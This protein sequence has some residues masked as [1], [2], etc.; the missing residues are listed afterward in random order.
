MKRCIAF[1][2]WVMCSFAPAAR[3]CMAQETQAA[4][5]RPDR[6]ED[7]IPYP[8]RVAA[9]E[10]LR[11]SAQ[12]MAFSPHVPNR[13]ERMVA[14]V[15]Y[16]HRLDGKDEE[17]NRLL[18]FVYR[19]QGQIE[20]ELAAV[21]VLRRACPEDHETAMRWLGLNLDMRDRDTEQRVSFLTEQISRDDLSD[22]LCAEA[23]SQLAYIYR[24][25][26]DLEQARQMLREALS[27]D[28]YN[29]TAIKGL[30]ELS[31][32]E[33][34]PIEGR[35]A[36]M[37]D[38]VAGR[39]NPE[40]VATAMDVALAMGDKG[41]YSGALEFF[42][43]LAGAPA[44]G[45]DQP[46]FALAYLSALLDAGQY[47]RA[48]EIFQPRIEKFEQDTDFLSLMVETYRAAG[49][50]QDARRVIDRME[51]YYKTRKSAAELKP[52]FLMELA[53]FNLHTLERPAVALGYARQAEGSVG[54]DPVLKRILGA[55]EL[56]S[57]R[58]ELVASGRQRLEK[59]LDSDVYAAAYLAE[60]YFEAGRNEDARRVILAGAE[61]TRSGPAY[62]QLS[63]VAEEHDVEMPPAPDK[64]DKI[65][66]VVRKFDRRYLRMLRAPSEF[67]SVRIGIPPRPVPVGEAVRLSVTLTNRGDIDVPLGQWGLIRPS[68]GFI[69]N[70]TDSDGEKRTFGNLPILNLPAPAR[71]AP[72]KSIS[73][74][75]RIDVGE[76]ERYLARRPLDTFTMS[77]K[78]VVDPVQQGVNIVSAAPKIDAGDVRVTRAGL[79]RWHRLQGNMSDFNPDDRGTWPDAYRRLMGLIV[80]DLQK[81]DIQVRMRAARQIA[82]LL[83]LARGV[84]I[85]RSAPP[86]QLTG[87]IKKPVLLTMTK[88]ALE[89]DSPVVRAESLTYMQY[90]ELDSRIIS[91][92]APIVN[93][94]Q[95]PAIV[96]F[97]LVELLGASDRVKQTTII[98]YYAQDTHEMVRL[99]A[100]AFGKT[101][102]GR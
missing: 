89:D 41:L 23:M 33:D 2:L 88:A 31:G 36:R 79:L 40:A 10:S 54:R 67:I 48:I 97:R 52:A 32:K 7:R 85:G 99:M 3:P 38:L 4:E 72:G 18:A 76:L 35:I 83:A 56:V 81:G 19:S 39:R 65:A 90:V 53:W 28:K 12:N 93:D 1:I 60:H 87:V 68:V 49:R 62:R 57:G 37:L 24:A 29:P 51:E 13:A 84:E 77:I 42:D 98:D 69:V 61:L 15:R 100:S 44:T 6:V 91:L 9:I 101:V 16:A 95:A 58:E 75:V 8:A 82:S 86:K 30:L 92:M 27:L 14:L 96:K 78:V 74:S 80:R 11:H 71:L 17:V 73:R 45:P 5:T 66:E 94:R 63:T 59:L 22:A 46:D 26:G 70:L 21:E 25:R 50:E 102:G 20:K 64:A 55:A 47:R 34:M 43:A